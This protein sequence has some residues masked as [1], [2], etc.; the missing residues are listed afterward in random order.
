MTSLISRK[1]QAV[2]LTSTLLMPVAAGTAMAND[3]SKKESRTRGTVIGAV[4]GALLGG[5]KGAVIGAAVGNGV[6][7]VR[8]SRH[9][10]YR[11]VRTTRYNTKTHRYYTATR[12]VYY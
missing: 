1:I 5:K 12:R 11:V 3:W 10:H 9:R 2:I 6:Q 8:H 7:A 4:A